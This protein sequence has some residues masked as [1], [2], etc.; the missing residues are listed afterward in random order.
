MSLESS[1]LEY[2]VRL[3]YFIGMFVTCSGSDF[4]CNSGTVLIGLLGQT[5]ATQLLKSGFNQ[6]KFY[7]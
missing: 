3:R 7:Y 2:F 5:T 1:V 4:T 6:L